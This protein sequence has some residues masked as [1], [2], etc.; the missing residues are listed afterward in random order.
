MK[1]YLVEMLACCGCGSSS[2]GKIV[3]GAGTGGGGEDGDSIFNEVVALESN[4]VCLVGV[5]CLV[6]VT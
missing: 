2:L 4:L 3:L 6:L 5:C 1:I